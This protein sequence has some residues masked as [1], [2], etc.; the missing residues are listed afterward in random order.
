ME[1]KQTQTNQKSPADTIHGAWVRKHKCQEINFGTQGREHSSHGTTSLINHKMNF[2][3]NILVNHAKWVLLNN[4]NKSQEHKIKG[5]LC[6]GTKWF[7]DP[8]SLHSYFVIFSYLI[9]S[10]LSMSFQCL[11][12]KLQGT[13]QLS[14]TILPNL[15]SLSS[16]TVTFWCHQSSCILFFTFPSPSKWWFSFLTPHPQVGLWSALDASGRRGRDGGLCMG[17]MRKWRM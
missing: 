12:S 7:N 11:P 4:F 5:C 3:N 13:K 10:K 15:I 2:V 6:E 9:P 1:A 16:P 17:H 14:L 8:I